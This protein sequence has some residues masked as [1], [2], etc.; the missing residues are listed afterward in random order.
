MQQNT[1][2]KGKFYCLYYANLLTWAL[3][4]LLIGQTTFLSANQIPS[5][6]LNQRQL[7]DL[8][9]LLNEG[10]Y[11]L[12]GFMDKATY[13]N[14][15]HNMR[16]LD[17]S[18]W[19]MPIVLD[20]KHDFLNKIK[21]LEKIELKSPEGITLA[22]LTITDIWSPDK[23]V[24]AKK[25]YGT[26]NIEH[27][28][29]FYLLHQ[30]EDY[31]I[32]GKITKVA[33]PKHY[34]FESLRKTPAELKAFFK[35]KKLEKV[36]AFQTRNPMHRA[37]L[38]LTLRAAEEVGAYLLIQPVV[39]MTKPGDIDY[40][41]RVK[42][43][44]KLLKYYPEGTAKLSLLPLSMRMAGPREALWHAIIR[45]NYG[46]T[47]FIVGRDHAG[48]G[49]DS[50][51]IDFYEPYAAQEL[52]KTYSNEIGIEVVPF[53]EM[54]YV[55]E[56]DNYQ[57]IDKVDP[58]KTAL[59]ISGTQLRA[60]LREGKEIPSWFSFPE[61]I[62]ELR[63][64]FPQRTKQGFTLFLTGFS[65]AG[66]STIANALGVRLMETQDRPVTLLDG[67]LVR[68]HL[69]TELGFSKEHRSLNVRRI[70]F[71][72]SE[73]TKN[74]GAA[75]CALI[76]PYEADRLYNRNMISSIGNYI[77]VYIS[78]PLEVCEARDVKGLYASAR[79][80]KLKNFT[81]IDDPYEIPTNPEIIIDASQIKITE[82]VDC[83]FNYLV[84]EH[85]LN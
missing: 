83:I 2:K 77:E 16:L 55:K 59:T 52:V 26:T 21:D 18:V 47:H 11:P 67:D 63:K 46:C 37:H 57:P 35:E 48:P 24:E 27:P 30:T 66:K 4:L 17:G 80:G 75:I 42:C 36:V 41:T 32:G 53:M 78:T 43:Y 8:E 64:V 25:V 28:G 81:G 5:L 44:R 69:S 58:N 14:V 34:D 50:K 6:T 7:C 20:V 49:K 33:M 29:V 40:F 10:F 22:H 31:Y 76:A 60:F 56:D 61:V 19:P 13:D 84:N 85:Y 70:G 15:V 12:E 65:G 79:E 45:R 73:I 74:G 68:A 62:K 23:L 3:F 71:V 82:A 51:G 39:G 9:L 1:C 54:V 72:A 38:E